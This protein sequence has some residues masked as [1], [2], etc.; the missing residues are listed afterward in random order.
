[1]KELAAVALE[2]AVANPP[3]RAAVALEQ[4]VANPSIRVEPQ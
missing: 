2:Q 4:A 3:I 1:M